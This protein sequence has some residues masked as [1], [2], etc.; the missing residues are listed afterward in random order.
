MSVF[1]SYSPAIL[2]RAI[3]VVPIKIKLYSYVWLQL[4]N[5]QFTFDRTNGLTMA[6]CAVE[7]CSY[8]WICFNKSCVSKDCIIIIAFSSAVSL[9]HSHTG[10]CLIKTNFC[11]YCT[12]FQ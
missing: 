12:L 11:T 1:V 3:P 4:Y 2:R 6:A 10:F 9:K 7:T 5:F 8:Y